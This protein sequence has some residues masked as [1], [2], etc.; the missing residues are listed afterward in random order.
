ML[1]SVKVLTRHSAI[2][3]LIIGSTAFAA[4]Y[5]VLLIGYYTLNFPLNMATTLGFFTG[6]IISFSINKSWVFGGRH[7]KH[8]VRQLI[9]YSLLVAFNYI[10]TVWFVGYFNTLGL[11]PAIGKLIAMGLIV[12]WNYVLFRWVIFTYKNS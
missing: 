2:R 10:F 1:R 12:C 7:R 4:D 9:E 8:V 5:I 11:A 6:F 3:Y